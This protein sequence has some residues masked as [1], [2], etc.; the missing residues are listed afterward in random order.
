MKL[1]LV[2]DLVTEI[3][4]VPILK[5][6]NAQ[7][8]SDVSPPKTQ[9]WQVK[10]WDPGAYIPRDKRLMVKLPFLTFDVANSCY[11][12]PCQICYANA[13]RV[14]TT[15]RAFL[16]NDLLGVRIRIS[17]AMTS[18]MINTPPRSS[19]PGRAG[20]NLE[21]T[22]TKFSRFSRAGDAL[23]RIQVANAI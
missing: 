5:H 4:S 12:L 21:N 7:R 9:G 17:I 16:P 11:V 2:W 8:S 13:N 6:L 20:H 23:A 14:S 18:L 3:H 22:F 10:T 19:W 15:V 1:V